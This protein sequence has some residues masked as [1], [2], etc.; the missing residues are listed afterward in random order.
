MDV[1]LKASAGV[2]V[3]VVLI[4]T[5]SKQSKDISLLLTI[6]VCCMVIVGAVKYLQPVADFLKRLQQIGN[7]DTE[8]FSVLLKAVGI[9]LLA[10]FTSL[11]C[12]DAGN[13]SLGKATQ[14]MATAAIVWISI[15]LLDKLIELID[16]ILGAI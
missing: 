6:A 3:A 14:L 4:L 5:L 10:E 12:T 11:V 15:P 2:L 8:I 13:S 9:G 7:L 16:N 1:F